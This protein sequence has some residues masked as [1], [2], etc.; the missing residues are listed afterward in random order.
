MQGVQMQR[1]LYASLAMPASLSVQGV[2][3]SIDCMPSLPDAEKR[4]RS[5]LHVMTQYYTGI[6]M[7][8]S[9]A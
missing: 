2:R 4:L 3:G 6:M 7:I 5:S 9:L 8:T 1:C